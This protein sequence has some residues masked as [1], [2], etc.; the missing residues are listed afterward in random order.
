MTVI[1]KSNVASAHSVGNLHGYSGPTDYVAMLDFSRGVYFTTVGGRTDLELSEAVSV[2]RSSAAPY[3]TKAGVLASVPANTPRITYLPD[4]KVSG[5]LVEAPRTNLAASASSQ[6]INVPAASASNR[7]ML[8]YRGGSASLSAGEL[9][10]EQEFTANGRTV[11]KYTRSVGTAFSATLTASGASELVVCDAAF[12]DYTGEFGGYSTTVASET[13]SLSAA[14]VALLSGGSGTV[15]VRHL[16]N[17]AGATDARLTFNNIAVKSAS[18]Q[19]GIYAVNSYQR[20]GVGTMSLITAPDGAA[21]NA[22]RTTRVSV[23]GTM[24][25][26]YVT[27]VTWDGLGDSVGI[28]DAG[29]QNRATGLGALFGVPASVNIGGDSGSITGG[30]RLGGIITHVVV[31]DRILSEAEAVVAASGWA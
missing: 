31:Y 24:A 7:V 17:A 12:G 18:P 10:L 14:I 13:A 30:S 15:L 9:T 26:G 6:T 23:T 16:F 11:K 21:I 25:R 19:G 4:D 28:I 20:A 22:S 3:V 5:L 1:I 27:G 29:L 8:S 2:S